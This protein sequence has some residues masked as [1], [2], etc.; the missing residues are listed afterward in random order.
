M[1]HEI[2]LGSMHC[3]RCAAN[4]ERYLRAQP[5]VEAADVDFEAGRGRVLVGP[6]AD[7]ET[8]LEAVEAMGYDATLV[9]RS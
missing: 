7:I 8:L 5:G 6:E 3:E 9:D 1:D 2:R 4:V